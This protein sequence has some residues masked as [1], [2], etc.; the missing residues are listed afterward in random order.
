M[1]SKF[2]YLL[3]FIFIALFPA[4]AV[5]TNSLPFVS[6][7]FSDNMVLQRGKPNPIWGWAKAG[8]VINVEIAGHI[9]KA[10]TG[11]DGRWQAEIQPPAPGGPYTLRI[12]GPVSLDRKSVV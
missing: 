6:P 11:A 4:M 5:D 3:I 8:E 9:A 1:R 12:I 2:P 10:V 7:M